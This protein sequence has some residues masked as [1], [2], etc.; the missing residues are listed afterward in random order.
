MKER[1]RKNKERVRVRVEKYDKVRKTNCTPNCTLL[2]HH[3][4]QGMSI[5][6]AF[7][8]SHQ[9]LLSPR[10]FFT[11]FIVSTCFGGPV[12]VPW[13]PYFNN[14]FTFLGIS[15]ILPALCCRKHSNRR[16]HSMC[17]R[18][19]AMVFETIWIGNSR[20]WL[21]PISVLLTH[22]T[23]T[24]AN[25]RLSISLTFDTQH[26]AFIHLSLALAPLP[27][28]FYTFIICLSVTQTLFSEF[29]CQNSLQQ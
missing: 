15:T 4:R 26:H 19:M 29:M 9:I 8:D 23:S 1:E 2:T 17:V 25:E 28:L 13:P 21:Q 27:T 20:V 14:R 7:T 11:Y 18:L 24:E 10:I 22:L 6:T 5:K 12:I 16:A 3:F